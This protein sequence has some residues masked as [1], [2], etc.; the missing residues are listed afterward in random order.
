VLGFRRWAVQPFA[1]ETCLTE[2]FEPPPGQD[3]EIFGS[4]G[5][6]VDHN[7]LVWVDWRDSGHFTAFDR[8]KCKTTK[9]PQATGQ[10]CPEGWT[11]YRN[12]NLSRN[13]R[14][15]AKIDVIDGRIEDH[16]YHAKPS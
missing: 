16:A 7:G 1:P 2:F 13:I 4:G 12:T 9:D 6:E 8:S 10:S 15:K 11:V 14:T 3:I 5:V